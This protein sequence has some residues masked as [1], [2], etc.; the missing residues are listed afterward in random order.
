VLHARVCAWEC[1]SGYLS[2]VISCILCMSEEEKAQVRVREKTLCVLLPCV[3]MSLLQPLAKTN[4]RLLSWQL[5]GSG[6]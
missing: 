5:V 4:R 2:H 1:W 3:W 6:W